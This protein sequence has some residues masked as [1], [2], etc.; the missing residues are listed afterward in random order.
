MD[1]A[2]IVEL[3][4]SRD[5]SAISQTAQKYGARLRRLSYRILGDKRAAEECENSTYFEAWNLIPPNEPKTYFFVFLASIARHI[6]IDE[7]RKNS[8]EKRSAMIC[9]LTREMEECIPDGSNIEGDIDA[10]DLRRAI[11]SFLA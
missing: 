10:D 8:A 1:D 7:C 11:N 2:G 9:E 4:L 3:Y 6:A 5:E